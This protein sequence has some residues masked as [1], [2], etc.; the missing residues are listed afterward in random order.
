MT[1]A[2]TPQADLPNQVTIL[3]AGP[4]KKKI[5]VEVPAATV[6]ARLA[7]QLDNLMNDA[8]LPGFRKGRAPRRLIEKRFGSMVRSQ[9]RDQLV[10]TSV[11]KAIEDHKLRVLGQP[12]GEGLEKIDIV[13][14]QPLKFEVE[15]E[16]SPDFKLP[17]LSGLKLKKPAIPVTDEMV[18]DELKKF[19]IQE[20]TLDERAAAEPGDY[21]TGHAKM[22]GPDGKVYFESDG[23]VVQLPPADKAPKGMIVGLVVDDLSTQ[24]GAVKPGETATVKTTGPANHE[25]EALRGLALTVTYAPA[26]VDRIIPADADEL[27]KRSGLADANAL[28]DIIKQ[29][30]QQRVLIDQVVAMRQQV[31]KH[32]IDTIQMDLPDRFTSGQASRNLERRRLELMYRGLDPQKIEEAVAELRS[33]SLKG[34]QND[35]KVFFILDKAAEELK[36]GVSEQEVNG[37][38]AQIAM[39]RNERPERLRQALIQSNQVSGIALQIREHKT[40]DTIISKASVEELPLEDYNKMVRELADKA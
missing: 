16:V 17:D 3:D 14:G 11:G 37:R 26:R 4:C 1:A 38:I 13:E 2:A 28:K 5:K 21:L 39:E 30:L 31:T 12:S 33:A 7:D 23:I 6:T 35:L 40:L 18:G 29:R 19:C 20:G 22:T 10:S 24:L 32:L 15:V 27:A 8:E 9:T 25:N 34:A 36:V